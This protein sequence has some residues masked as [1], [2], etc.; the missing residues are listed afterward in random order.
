MPLPSTS[1]PL[2]RKQ[3]YGQLIVEKA[4]FMIK[5]SNLW[6]RDLIS[7]TRPSCFLEFVLSLQNLFWFWPSLG[8]ASDPPLT[9][10]PAADASSHFLLYRTIHSCLGS[11]LIKKLLSWSNTW[12]R[13]VVSQC[14]CETTPAKPAKPLW[15]HGF[16][17]KI[18]FILS[19]WG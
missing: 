10:W 11:W 2:P 1:V 7:A 17:E 18:F 19:F 4:S 15:N 3:T 9:F 8:F 14:L 13:K 5:S 16:T 12:F 6:S